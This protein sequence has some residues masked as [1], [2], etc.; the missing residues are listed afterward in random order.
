MSVNRRFVHTPSNRR[1]NTRLKDLLEKFKAPPP[2]RTFALRKENKINAPLT[3]MRACQV[4]QIYSG[5]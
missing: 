5:C 4:N 1:V 3:G 2:P